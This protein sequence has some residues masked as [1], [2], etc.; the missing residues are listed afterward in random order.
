MLGLLVLLSLNSSDSEASKKSALANLAEVTEQYGEGWEGVGDVQIRK[1]KKDGWTSFDV[2]LVKSNCYRFIL[3]GD[4]KGLSLGITIKKGGK[5][6]IDAFR[7]VKAGVL[8]LCP[9]EEGEFQVRSIA[10][11]G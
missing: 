3:V 4:R 7:L 6:Y 10:C 9:V 5:T 2:D 1:V 8:D 11:T